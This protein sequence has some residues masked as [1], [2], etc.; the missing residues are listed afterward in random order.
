[1]GCLTV[2]ENFDLH[3]GR[4]Y[5]PDLRV[6]QKSHGGSRARKCYEARHMLG[7]FM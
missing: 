4:N 7:R 5:L 2:L 1:M 3:K 6:K